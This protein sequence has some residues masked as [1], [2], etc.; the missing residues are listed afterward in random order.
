MPSAIK[1][2]I[3]EDFS[4]PSS[5]KE[6][7]FAVDEKK[8]IFMF[9]RSEGQTPK[10]KAQTL[11]TKHKSTNGD[12]INF[13]PVLEESDGTLRLFYLIPWLIDLIQGD[14]VIVIDELERSLHANL[15]YAFI[16]FYLTASSKANV[17]SQLIISTHESSILTQELLRKDEIWFATKTKQGSTKLNSLEEYKVRQDKE[18]MR[19]YLIGRFR[20]I[21]NIGSSEH[22]TDVL[23]NEDGKK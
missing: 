4:D 14:N 18:L 22:L 11:V 17:N 6:V 13:N 7:G 15:V 1:E 8:Q 21:P 20:A 9:T 3:S 2:K 5:E 10:I 19:S 12:L 16:E 23:A